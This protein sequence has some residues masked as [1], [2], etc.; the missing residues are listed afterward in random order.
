MAKKKKDGDLQKVEIVQP[1]RSRAFGVILYP[2]ED[3]KHA[4]LLDW[5]C[6]YEHVIWIKHDMDR[7]VSDVIEDGVLIHKKGDFKKPHIHLMFLYDQPKTL[8]PIIKK[9][10]EFYNC[11]LKPS[12]QIEAFHVECISSVNDYVLYMLHR[13]LQAQYE[14]KYQYNPLLIQGDKKLAAEIL[15]LALDDR[16][17]IVEIINFV[18]N[19][20]LSF[21]KLIQSVCSGELP[22][23]WYSFVMKHQNMFKQIC[24]DC[25]FEK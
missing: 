10:T 11:D 1:K 5:L 9:F 14:N 18:N 24:A 12:E 21:S 4:F 22:D 8:N 23:Y 25:R 19:K 16:S 2:D 13:T 17:I 6:K 3:V 20:N 15:N 7:Y